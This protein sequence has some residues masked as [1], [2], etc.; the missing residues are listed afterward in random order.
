MYFTVLM[1]FAQKPFR[2]FSSSSLCSPAVKG[3][4]GGVAERP[5]ALIYSQ[6]YGTT[7]LRFRAT[8]RRPHLISKVLWWGYGLEYTGYKTFR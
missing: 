5:T 4:E 2:H 1:S 7:S 8:F 3:Y 6:Y